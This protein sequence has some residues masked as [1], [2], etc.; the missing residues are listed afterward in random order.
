VSAKR[1]AARARQVANDGEHFPDVGP[2][3]VAK[4]Q[5]HVELMKDNKYAERFCRLQG[6]AQVMA[7]AF[8]RRVRGGAHLQLNFVQCFVYTVRDPR[9]PGGEAQFLAEH[10]LEGKFIKFNNN[11]GAVNPLAVAPQRRKAAPVHFALDEIGA[12]SALVKIGTDLV[13]PSALRVR[14]ADA[15]SPARRRA[16]ER[17]GR[18]ADED[19]DEWS[20]GSPVGSSCS[21]RAAEISADDI[22]QVHSWH[23]PRQVA[24]APP[25]ALGL[26]RSVSRL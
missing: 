14:G 17:E 16:S 18:G 25:A 11:A 3:L 20:D 23:L 8:N 26:P 12:P 7:Q 4:E 9:W 13:V 6:Q 15:A 21:S 24:A 19:K 1:R 5:Q 22:P 10:Y 2:R